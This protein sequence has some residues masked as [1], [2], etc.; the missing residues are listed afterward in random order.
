MDEQ[1]ILIFFIQE[2]KQY[3]PLSEME[4]QDYLKQYN[5]TKEK[6]VLEKLALHNL[7]LAITVAK[8][9]QNQCKTLSLLDLIQENYL[10]MRKAISLFDMNRGTKLSTYIYRSLQ[11]ALQRTIDKKDNTI[12]V[13]PKMRAKER[14]YYKFIDEYLNECG[15]MPSEEEIKKE[16][17]I[18]H[19]QQK[20]I[21]NLKTFNS[22]SLNSL[23]IYKNMI[24]EQIEFI[25][26]I[27]DNYTNVEQK[28]NVLILLKSLFEVLDRRSYYILYNRLIVGLT[29]EQVGKKLEITSERVRVLENKALKRVKPVFEKIQKRTI[30][31]YGYNKFDT[32]ELIPLDPKL[33]LAMYYLKSDLGELPYH[34]VY[35]KLCDKKN[36][37]LEYYKT[38]FLQ[39]KEDKI[40]QTV[41]MVPEF[42]DIFLK[43]ENIEEINVKYRQSLSIREI[44]DLDIK[45][46]PAPTFNSSCLLEENEEYKMALK[47]LNMLVSLEQ[48]ETH[49]YIK[50]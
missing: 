21:K 38:C 15:K 5:E 36:D 49:T 47:N 22:I 31:T 7:F 39:E 32:R 20:T 37:Q 10:T 46:E 14:K 19:S 13:G 27:D 9:F 50:K 12:K 6:E 25:G 42:M 2:I 23:V 33:R 34:V 8:Q 3:K 28:Q 4:T 29:Q 11:S 45:P 16:T 17:Q 1:E 18:D 48:K 24:G 41:Q 40:K 43:P 30:V 35:T 44:F 26:T